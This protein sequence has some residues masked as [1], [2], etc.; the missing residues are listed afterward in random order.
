MQARFICLLAGFSSAA[1]CAV[2]GGV[3]RGPN[4]VAILFEEGNYA[5]VTLGYGSPDVSGTAFGGASGNM[6]GSYLT[7]SLGIKQSLSDKLDFAIIMNEPIGADVDYATGTGYALEGTTA[8]LQAAAIT[9]EPT[10]DLVARV[11]V[12]G[13]AL[14]DDL[15]TSAVIDFYRPL[16]PLSRSCAPI[17]SV[18]RSGGVHCAWAR[19]RPLVHPPELARCPGMIDCLESTSGPGLR[20]C[21]DRRSQVQRW[22][23]DEHRHRFPCHARHPHRASECSPAKRLPW[24]GP[25]LRTA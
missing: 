4:S 11:R 7:Y 5:E 6:L 23:S 8:N 18:L 17:R 16:S 9:G 12:V 2:A 19:R 24:P 20:G 15:R 21:L 25:T 13:S 1:T 10:P 3:E 14:F 22:R